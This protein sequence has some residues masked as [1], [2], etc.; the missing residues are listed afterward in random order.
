[1]ELSRTALAHA[2][3]RLVAGRRVSITETRTRVA[4]YQL[5][6]REA[7]ELAD[8]FVKAGF[9]EPEISDE[10][11]RA[12]LSALAPD[13][14]GI[15]MLVDKPTVPDAVYP[16]LT[17]RGLEAIFDRAPDEAVVWING[18][19]HAVDT[20]TVR[21]AGWGYIDSFH[22]VAEPASPDRFVRSFTP[23]ELTGRW[24]LRDA[25]TDLSGAALAPWRTRAV[26]VLARAIGQEIEADGTVLFR[27]PPPARFR[28]VGADNVELSNL[29]ALQK[30][31]AWVFENAPEAENRHGLLAAEVA[32][33]VVRDGDLN[34]LAGTMRPALEGARIAYG[35]GVSQQSRD[36]LKALAELRK[37]VGDETA[38]LAET[39]RGLAAAVAGA[40]FGNI[41]IIILR[42]S[43]PKDA[44][45][46]KPAAL[47]LALVLASYVGSVIVGGA[48]FLSIQRDLRRDWRDRLYRFLTK[49]EYDTMVTQPIARAEGAFKVAA[50][51]GAALAG[52]VLIAVVLVVIATPVTRP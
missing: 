24:L 2:L 10:G 17:R 22:P 51:I 7:V 52:V 34:D 11:G 30:A 41:G 35:F 18:L 15:E 43:L 26:Q 32:R 13:A 20:L 16:V 31:A 9:G 1:M 27:G 44:T 37:A 3:D 25:D 47:L 38:K 28:P 14:S 19:D 8:L 29:A 5:V 4:V 49:D 12:D 42:L 50:G 40:L 39:V 33:T 45:F 21:Y 36:S 6:G 48:Q 46:I 23:V